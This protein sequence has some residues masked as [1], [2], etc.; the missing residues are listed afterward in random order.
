MINSTIKFFFKKNHLNL[1][2][3]FDI[4]AVCQ[5]Y[6]SIYRIPMIHQCQTPFSRPT[7]PPQGLFNSSLPSFTEIDKS[8]TLSTVSQSFLI[9][10]HIIFNPFPM[11]GVLNSRPLRYLDISSI[12]RNK[13]YGPSTC[14][15]HG[16][17]FSKF[18]GLTTKKI[19]RLAF[20]RCLALTVAMTTVDFECNVSG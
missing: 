10:P 13:T 18:S 12:D 16:W 15:T 19:Q 4:T 2:L 5:R 14:Q 8:S 3:L 7:A 20:G 6:Q 17:I 1:H 9:L 11:V